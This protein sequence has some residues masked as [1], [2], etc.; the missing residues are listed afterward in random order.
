[1]QVVRDAQSCALCPSPV[2]CCARQEG[3]GEPLGQERGATA[4]WSAGPDPEAHGSFSSASSLTDKVPHR[5]RA[6]ALSSCSLGERAQPPRSRM[7]R[8]AK[9]PDRATSG[10]AWGSPGPKAGDA[11][12]TAGV[13]AEQMLWIDFI[14]LQPAVPVG[15]MAAAKKAERFVFMACA[16]P[17]TMWLLPAAGPALRLR[18][19]CENDVSAE[20]RS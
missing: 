16:M 10:Y 19:A 11:F 15:A 12:A 8:S 13:R 14:R 7:T 9:P 1:M 5:R 3:G 20:R 6:P 18:Q 2:L 17:C 4:G